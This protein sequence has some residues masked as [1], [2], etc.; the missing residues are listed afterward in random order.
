MQ[1]I[2]LFSSKIGGTCPP[3]HPVIDAHGE[4]SRNVNVWNMKITMKHGTELTGTELII[5]AQVMIWGVATKR[6]EAKT[7]TT[8]TTP[9]FYCCGFVAT[10]WEKCNRFEGFLRLLTPFSSTIIVWF[11]PASIRFCRSFSPCR[12]WRLRYSR[13]VDCKLSLRV[14]NKPTSAPVRPYLVCCTLCV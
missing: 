11:Q 4:C 3:V 1:K 8:E 13:R 10:A 5:R 7:A 14:S 9:F 12:D 6:L 2:S